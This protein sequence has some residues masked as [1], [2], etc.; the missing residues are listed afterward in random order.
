M[1]RLWHNWR[2]TLT[3][4]NRCDCR[5]AS[6]NLGYITSTDWLCSLLTLQTLVRWCYKNITLQVSLL[7]MTFHDDVS[8]ICHDN[9]SLI[10]QMCH[11]NMSLICHYN[12]SL[13]CQ[14]CHDDV[15]LICQMCHWCVIIICHWYVWCV[16]IIYQRYRSYLLQR[17]VIN[18]FDVSS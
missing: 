18:V 13:T 8:L 1:A 6:V 4:K 16:F 14:M 11:D 15:L 17:Y 7:S 5:Q 10:C 9:V 2:L 3:N 12:V